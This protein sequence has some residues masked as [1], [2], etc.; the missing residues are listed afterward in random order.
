MTGMPNGAQSI[1][2]AR[3][4]GM[5]P[6]EMLIVSMIGPVNES[7]H[8]VYANPIMEYD[9]RWLVGL[10][11]CLYVKP[12]I[13][14]RKAAMDIARCKPEWFGVYDAAQMKG[15]DVYSLPVV[16]DIAKPSTHWRYKLH[17]IPW[18]EFQ[19]FQFAWSE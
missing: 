13:D 5:K 4:R 12:G 7:N 15:T 14:W 8:T 11:V 3:Q 9:W 18:M 17:F 2:A 19:N 16:E 6:A 1:L 10:K